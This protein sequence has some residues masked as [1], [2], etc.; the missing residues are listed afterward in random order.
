M[1]KKAFSLGAVISILLCFATL[2]VWPQ[3]ADHPW[4]MYQHDPQHT[5][6]SDYVGPS[7]SAVKWTFD[8]SGQP[9]TGPV[10]DQNGTIYLGVTTGLLAIKE[11]GGMPKKQWLFETETSRFYGTP[12]IGPD[13]TIY[14]INGYD[15]ITAVFPVGSLKWQVELTH[16]INM[17]YPHT[18]NRLNLKGGILYFS[19]SYWLQGHRHPLL[20]AFNKDTGNLLW[21]FD[22]AGEQKYTNLN[23]IPS[24]SDI[25]AYPSLPTIGR[26]GNVYVGFGPTL[27][28]IDS[29]GNL[30]WKKVFQIQ[31]D[32]ENE[33][34]TTFGTISVSDD[35]TIYFVLKNKTYYYYGSGPF[36]HNHVCSLLPDSLESKWEP[37]RVFNDQGPILISKTGTLYLALT[38]KN[39][40]YQIT[41]DGTLTQFDNEAIQ[42]SARFIDSQDKIYGDKGNF[43]H[44]FAAVNSE[45]EIILSYPQDRFIFPFAL[46]KDGILYAPSFDYLYA[47]GSIPENQPPRQPTNISPVSGAT[48]VVLT[49]TLESSPFSDPDPGDF[50]TASQWQITTVPGHYAPPATYVFDSG[51][52]TQNLTAIT[53]PSGELEFGITYYWHVRY[54]DNNGNWSEWSEETSFTTIIFS[55]E[56]IFLNCVTL[57]NGQIFERFLTKASE[58]AITAKICK[59]G[60]ATDMQVR[61]SDKTTGDQIGDVKALTMVAGNITTYVNQIW[62]LSS[63]VEDHEIQVE[64]LGTNQSASR[65][66]SVYYD[67]GTPFDLII[68]AYQFANDEAL[69]ESLGIPGIDIGID[70]YA[71]TTRAVI[72]SHSDKDEGGYCAGMAATSI[73]YKEYPLLKPDGQYE[74]VWDMRPEDPHVAEKIRQYQEGYSR[75]YGLVCSPGSSER[76]WWGSSEVKYKAIKNS[77]SGDSDHPVILVMNTNS[78]W[79]PHRWGTTHTVVAYKIIDLGNE[80]RV[81]IYD[82]NF[83]ADG[84]AKI[85][86]AC[87]YVA[88]DLDND[89]FITPQRELFDPNRGFY[90]E[91]THLD[92]YKQVIVTFPKPE[93]PDEEELKESLQAAFNYFNDF[94]ETE[95]LAAVMFASPVEA[96][97]TDQHG[98]RIGYVQGSFI[99]EIPDA[100][101]EELSSVKIYYVPAEL[102]YVIKATGTDSGTL[103]L[104]YMIPKG[105]YIFEAIYGGVPIDVGNIILAIMGQQVTDYV[106]Q[107]D[108][109]GDG[110]TDE[111][112]HPDSIDF[113]ADIRVAIDIKPGSY[114]NSIKVGSQG[115]IPVAILSTSDFDATQVD[116]STVSLSG[117]G[118]AIKGKGNTLAH[119]EDINGDGLIDLVVQ[120]ETEN[121]NPSELQTGKACLI[122]G[123]YAGDSIAGCDEIVIVPPESAPAKP[124]EFD[125]SQNYPNPFN[126]DTWIPY[127][128]AE[129]VNVTIRI[130]DAS[131]RLVRTLDLGR[132]PAGFYTNKVKAA[133]WDGRNEAGEQVASGIYFYTIQA[134]E[135]TATRKMLAVR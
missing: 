19:T 115:V 129:D 59:S 130:H 6:R 107:I 68:D 104:Y 32:W 113:I 77:L 52:D 12:L 76:C 48:G 13:G 112:R 46:S 72:A 5:G 110:V 114:P 132:K 127:Q 36:Y 105:D 39:Y 33:L 96:V 60:D 74:K 25:R 85:A 45:A 56:D 37:V 30:Q 27:F 98:R 63:D 125:L 16:A 22:L 38:N 120:V 28:A 124:T 131:G 29:Q 34:Q 92:T 15:K 80:K 71:L 109:N 55:I 3:L 121:L 122:G 89:K 95:N 58:V 44:R 101:I 54:Q 47:F 97:L 64:I 94:L 50:H 75:I 133:Y 86:I 135:F 126:P 11:E 26:D 123:T 134:G 57:R 18:E 67:D 84:E 31:D 8:I 117:A 2:N 119:Q 100:D 41:P 70:E 106:M 4:P 35:G 43:S 9:W 93:G 88:F 103:D 42:F 24:P 87:G 128:L 66:V 20:I 61:F 7:T 118:I 1:L 82:P 91:K 51:A 21:I 116:P 83:P 78:T 111:V 17:A 102:E 65:S 90:P 62:E 14:I 49:P 79:I 108:S 69:K 73:L 53:I 99:D 40:L 81:Y 10:I 23:E